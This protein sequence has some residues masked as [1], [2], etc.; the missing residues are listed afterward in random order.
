[1][2][3]SAR[4]RSLFIRVHM[5]VG[6]R[7]RAPAGLRAVGAR[8]YLRPLR[9]ILMPGARIEDADLLIQ[10]LIKLGKELDHLLIGIAMVDRHVVSRSMAQRAPDDRDAVLRKH[11]AAVLE[12]REV[13]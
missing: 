7:R 1:S 6:A 13:A 9:L 12:M 3:F 11:I 8:P 5:P 10:N 4:R 2:Y